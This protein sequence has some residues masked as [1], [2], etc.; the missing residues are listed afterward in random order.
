MARHVHPK[1]THFNKRCV[2]IVT[3]A[4][5]TRSTI[6]FSDG[7]TTEADVVLIADGIRSAVRSVVTGKPSEESLA[8]TGKVCYRALVPA[9]QA[10]AAGLR[11]DFHSRPVCV[12]GPEKVR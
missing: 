2:D 3:S 1:Y 11:A 6:H 10:H 4:D 12:A 7:T 5:N 8:Y 9:A